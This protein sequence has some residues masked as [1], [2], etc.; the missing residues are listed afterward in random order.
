MTQHVYD[1]GGGQAAGTSD[2]K[3]LLGG[4]GA[5]LAEMTRLGLPVPPGFTVSTATCLQFLAEDQ[6]L[7]GGAVEQVRLALGV[8]ESRMDR[9]FGDAGQPLLVSVRS[10]AAVWARTRLCRRI[11]AMFWSSTSCVLNAVPDWNIFR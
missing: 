1:F 3:D 6:T 9:R 4:K 10:G 5:N 2:Q 11:F 7:P 8:L